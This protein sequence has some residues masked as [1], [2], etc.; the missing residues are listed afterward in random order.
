MVQVNIDS[1]KG[2]VQKVGNN[3]VIAET[4]V[5]MRSGA[6]AGGSPSHTC[7]WQAHAEVGNGNQTITAAEVLTGILADDPE[8]NADWTLPTAALLVAAIPNVAVGDCIDFSVINEATST[9]DEKVTIV[10]GTSGTAVGLMV[11]DS[12]L[13]AGIRGSGSGMF[14][15]RFTGVASGSEAYTCYRMA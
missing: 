4:T 14:R 15:I 11:V 5:R 9:Q 12:Q 6:T 2:L 1:K 7:A 3:G 13:V 8:G 10:M